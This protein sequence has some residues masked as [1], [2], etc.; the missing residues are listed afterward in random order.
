MHDSLLQIERQAA[1]AALCSLLEGDIVRSAIVNIG[2]TLQSALAGRLLSYA[3]EL[4]A[5]DEEEAE[6][7]ATQLLQACLQIAPERLLPA[8]LHQHSM[9]ELLKQSYA[10]ALAA[11]DKALSCCEQLARESSGASD[12]TLMAHERDTSGTQ[13]HTATI[14][15]PM[16]VQE[17]ILA[18]KS[19]ENSVLGELVP[20]D[21]Q[22][23]A[24]LILRV[25]I[26]MEVRPPR[27]LRQVAQAIGSFGGA[28][29]T[30]GP[31]FSC[32]CQ[33]LL[34]AVTCFR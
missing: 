20:V 2:P 27:R 21:R 13:V 22:M 30:P 10:A 32:S 28:A 12:E 3:R 15:E 5:C 14:N 34:C 19:L 8:V 9:V 29:N 4:I 23:V 26:L 7:A 1:R 18:E 24:C 6:E 17:A 31:C 11:V 16:N 33:P 25:K